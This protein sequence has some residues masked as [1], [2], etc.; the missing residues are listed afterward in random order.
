[1]KIKYS[2]DQEINRDRVGHGL[3][4]EFVKIKYS[5]VGHIG[6]GLGR[7]H[8][9][10]STRLS[11]SGPLGQPQTET[12]EKSER[13]KPKEVNGQTKGSQEL[14]QPTCASLSTT[15]PHNTI[16]FSVSFFFNQYKHNGAPNLF[17]LWSS[18]LYLF[19]GYS[20]F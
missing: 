13:Q 6:L 9:S 17:L 3:S 11:L 14:A 10:L 15:P 4:A 16:H 2:V 19:R 1:M 12:E 18:L 7:R 8:L 20:Q 5:V